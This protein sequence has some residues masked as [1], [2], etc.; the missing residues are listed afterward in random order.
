[1]KVTVDIPDSDLEEV[2]AYT[3]EPKKGPAILKLVSEV[4]QL[5][6]RETLANKFITGEWGTKLSGID[7]A[8]TADRK[9]ARLR[10]QA[11]QT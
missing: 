6:R 3:G 11:W 8:R 7:S 5:K 4:L 10:A 1:M 9:S 2:C